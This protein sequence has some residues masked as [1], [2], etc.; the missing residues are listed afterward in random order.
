[1][2]KTKFKEYVANLSMHS[3]PAIIGFNENEG[4]FLTTYN[5]TN[6]DLETALEYSYDY[7]WC[8]ATLTT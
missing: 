2:S 3:K 8:P 6:P 1:M 4:L 7:F 5:A